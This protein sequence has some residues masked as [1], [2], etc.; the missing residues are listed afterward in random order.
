[1]LPCAITQ[2]EVDYFK[3]KK[4]HGAVIQGPTLAEIRQLLPVNNSNRV[5]C[6]AHICGIA[7]ERAKVINF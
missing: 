1:M 4:G 2:S 7:G 6:I 3:E 5:Q